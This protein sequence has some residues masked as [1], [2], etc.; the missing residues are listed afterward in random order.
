M[1]RSTDWDV[2]VLPLLVGGPG[3]RPGADWGVSLIPV[4]LTVERASHVKER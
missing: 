2:L 4:L 1:A 3:S